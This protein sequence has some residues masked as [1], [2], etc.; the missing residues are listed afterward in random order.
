MVTNPS[1]IILIIVMPIIIT[2]IIIII[3]IIIITI[4]SRGELRLPSGLRLLVLLPLSPLHL[5]LL[6][7]KP[8]PALLDRVA[9]LGQQA[10]LLRHLET[11]QKCFPLSRQ[12]PKTSQSSPSP[13]PSP[14]PYTQAP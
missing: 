12:F 6:G 5:G 7:L 13:P 10:A 11:H 14:P 1:C 4:N 3:I 2:I 8:Q 9:A